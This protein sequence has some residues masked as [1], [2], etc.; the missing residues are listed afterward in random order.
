MNEGDRQLAT[1]PGDEATGRVALPPSETVWAETPLRREDAEAILAAAGADV[2]GL[3]REALLLTLARIATFGV[4]LSWP[5]P[6]LVQ[7]RK[8]LAAAMF[9]LVRAVTVLRGTTAEPPP[10]P[11]EW[12][13]AMVEWMSVHVVD[14]RQRGA[15]PKIGDTFI[16]PNL[17]AVY[18]MITGL[19][20]AH[21]ENGP[22]VRFLETFFVKM[23]ERHAEAT[24]NSSDKPR[25]LH[26]GFWHRTRA[27]LRAR[28]RERPNLEQTHASL[29]AY[30]YLELLAT[31]ASPPGPD[32]V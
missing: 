21:T 26:S 15:P 8:A 10:I 3:H 24:S 32:N 27:A 22:T 19:D 9:E 13:N 7:E 30:H 1:P 6:A 4:L 20:P 18:S 16:I 28:I 31:V 23:S 5:R 14:K 11:K 29:M 17:L 2:D 12:A 25:I